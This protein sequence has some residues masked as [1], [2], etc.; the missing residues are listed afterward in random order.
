MIKNINAISKELNEKGFYLQQTL[1]SEYSI[2]QLKQLVEVKSRSTF[3]IRQFF[4]IFPGAKKIVFNNAFQ[5][6]FNR[7]I[8][9]EFRL[10]KAIYFDK[11][12]SANWVVP[13]HQDLTIVTEQKVD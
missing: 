1:F 13:W 11:P 7:Y 10:I 5:D 8:G 6:F 9:Q 3:A 4:K 2:S 12:P